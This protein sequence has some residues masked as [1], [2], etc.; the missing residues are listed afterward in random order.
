MGITA[1]TGAAAPAAGQSTAGLSGED[2]VLYKLVQRITFGVN[3]EEFAL[4]R[5]LGFEKYLEYHLSFEQIDDSSVLAMISGFT[6]LSME[7]YQYY[8]L[9]DTGLPMRETAE[10]MLFRA[11]F[12]K[13]QLLERVVEFWTDH[14]NIDQNKASFH[15]AINDR[16]AIRTAAMTNFRN[17]LQ[18][19]ATSPA[20]LIY[21]DNASSNASNGRSPNQNYARELMELHT[22]GVN[23]G[24]TQADVLA[25]AKALSGWTYYSSSADGVN[26]G[27]FRYNNALHDQTA[28]TILGVAFPAN[29]GQNDGNRLLDILANHPSTIQFVCT[30]LFR[31]FLDY[32][33]SQAALAPVMD[34]WVSSNGDIRTILGAILTR[35]N[36]MA[37][38]PK[39]KRPLHLMVSGIRAVRATVTNFN[40]LRGT[41]LRLAGHIPYNWSPPNGYPD[42]YGYW[43]GLLLPR[44]N[45]G[46]RVTQTGS[47]AISGITSNVTSLVTGLTTANAIAQRINQLLFQG[48][49]PAARVTALATYL[50]TGVPSAAK[51]RDAFGLALNLPEFQ[52]V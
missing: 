36:V 42:A 41:Q 22:L 27:K 32:T 37:A 50:G 16:D 45:F 12:S 20:M 1:L 21:L 2:A 43:V 7:P 33:P 28:K 14:F 52:W 18:K 49:L 46:F 13:R 30:K 15:K 48:S 29:Q 31:Y 51:I 6:T 10:A 35:Q 24:Y 3:D 47:L 23:G 25:A 5:T 38:A 34:A 44:W 40:T 8:A 26:R 17:L 11:V 4:A 9:T 39:Y 19:S